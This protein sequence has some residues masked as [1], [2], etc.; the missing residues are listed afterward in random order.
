MILRKIITMFKIIKCSISGVRFTNKLHSNI[1]SFSK[2]YNKG[3]KF[4]IGKAYIRNNVLINTDENGSIIIKDN[5]FAN[6]NSIISCR[7]KIIINENC[8][9]GPNVCIYDHDHKYGENGLENGYELG[10]VII[11]KNVWIGAGAI[12]LK[13][14]EIGD[15]CIIAAGTIVKGK[16]PSNSLIYNEKVTK[17]K[18]LKTNK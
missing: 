2:I 7:N 17:I 13:N 6:R 1:E 3:K 15:N 11:G 18:E 5:F 16:Y 4:E 8:C 10:Y 9:I 14:T 12:I